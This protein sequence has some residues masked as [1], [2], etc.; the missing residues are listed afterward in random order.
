MTVDRRIVGAVRSEEGEMAPGRRHAA[1]SA[2]GNELLL[3]LYVGEREEAVLVDGDD[4]CVG[5]NSAERR[6]KIAIGVSRDVGVAPL[7]Q[8]QKKIVGGLWQEVIFDEAGDEIIRRREAQLC[9][10]ARVVERRREAGGREQAGVSAQAAM[11]ARGALGT[12]LPRRRDRRRSH[13]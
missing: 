9:I 3:G 1:Q 5:A 10:A 7:A 12:S 8:Q 2:I 13:R 11:D 4:R 6:R